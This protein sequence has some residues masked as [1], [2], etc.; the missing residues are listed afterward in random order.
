[1]EL[2]ARLGNVD[3]QEFKY[4]SKPKEAAV[5][6]INKLLE[7]LKLPIGLASNPKELEKGLD[8]ILQ[9]SS[10]WAGKAINIKQVI[11]NDFTLWGEP[12]VQQHFLENYEN[13]ISLVVDE[14]GGFASKYN[15]PAKFN[16]LNLSLEQIEKK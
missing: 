15:T 9:A 13:D 16:N 8:K 3:M 7:I 5:R 4:I 2:T 14:F 1:M 6:E 12:L 11:N 10:D